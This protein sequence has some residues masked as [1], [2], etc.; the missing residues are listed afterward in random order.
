MVIPR[1]RKAG[2]RTRASVP[3]AVMV[4]VLMSPVQH[5]SAQNISEQNISANKLSARSL[6]AQDGPVYSLAALIDSASHYLPRLMEK[7]ALAKSA[8]MGVTDAKHAYLP[9]LNVADELSIGTANDLTGSFL[10][11]PG[12][13]HGIA[14]GITDGNNYQ[15]ASGNIASVYGEYEMVNFGLRGAK[16]DNA[17]AFAGLQKADFDK[18]FYLV[19]LQIGNLYFSILK[20]LYQLSVD[21]QNINRYQSMYSISRALTA[22]GINAG[23]DSSLA[24]AELSKTRVSFNQR[25][26]LLDRL[27]H[28]L[29]FLTGIPSSEIGIDTAGTRWR[30]AGPGW[31]IAG[32]PG[33]ANAGTPGQMKAGGGGATGAGSARGSGAA[34][35]GELFMDV[36]DTANNPLT[37]YFARQK[38]YYRSQETLVKKSYLPKVIL[39][40]GG[41]G[42]GSSIQY[43]N[44]Y[45]GLD[46]GL[47]Y[48]RLNYT[49]G[50]GITYDLF[51]GVHRKDRLAMAR[52][53][54][55]AADYALQQQRVSLGSEAAQAEDVIRTAQR[56]LEELPVQLQAATD[57]YNQKLA[58][59]KA[60][61]INLVD[62]V[63]ASFVLYAAQSD[64]IE[65][66]NDWYVAHLDK[67]AATGNLDL[68]IQTIDSFKP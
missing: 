48:Q 31:G 65:T 10:P 45:E 28:Q 26:G 68:F 35:R 66:L 5:I 21:E 18:E 3:F 52:Q 50:L 25:A 38:G 19:K 42:R 8:E 7:Q 36:P 41:W 47:G 30:T 43:N 60:G 20:N 23:V 51:N 37:E 56:N 40:A 58:Q 62:L 13:L 59:Y 33:Q 4:L 29:A 44:D 39:G 14:G 1:T 57:A 16:V 46:K 22:T 55:L 24:R 2:V 11:I 32:A 64:Y 63:T 54:T 61:I 6:S 34:G 27:R 67:A 49:A 12:L 15:A 9:K 53:Q 17:R